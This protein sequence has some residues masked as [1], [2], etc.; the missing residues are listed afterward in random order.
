MAAGSLTMPSSIVRNTTRSVVSTRVIFAAI[1]LIGTI[2]AID[3]VGKPAG[4]VVVVVLVV[5]LVVV[6]AVVVVGAEVV[7]GTVVDTNVESFAPESLEQAV[8]KRAMLPKIK[9]ESL[10]TVKICEFRAKLS[11]FTLCTLEE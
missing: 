6:E 11:R 10:P 3:A 8:I 1:P 4:R 2:G 5:V 7:E 9:G